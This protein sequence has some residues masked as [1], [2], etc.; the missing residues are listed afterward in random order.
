M[1]AAGRSKGYIFG[2]WSAIVVLSGLASLA[3]AA[4]FGGASHKIVAAV[5]AVATG[6]LLSWWPAVLAAVAFFV[7]G[8]EIRVRSEEK[9]LRERFGAEFD[10]YAARVPAYVPL[11]R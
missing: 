1:K 5:N 9:L 4:L 2:L 3:D 6:A 11:L 7:A 8:T 10:A